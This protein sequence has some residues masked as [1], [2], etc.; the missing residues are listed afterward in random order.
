MKEHKK[1]FNH[2]ETSVYTILKFKSTEVNLL[3]CLIGLSDKN[4]GV[5]VMVGQIIT[6]NQTPCEGSVMLPHI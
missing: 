3:S 2:G 5:G 1:Y 6:V 4:G